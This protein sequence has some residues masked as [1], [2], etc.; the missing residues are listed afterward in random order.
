MVNGG[1]LFID[2]DDP[3]GRSN[4]KKPASQRYNREAR[5]HVMRDI[6]FSRRKEKACVQ[7]PRL[8]PSC[9][10]PIVVDGQPKQHSGSHCR[11]NRCLQDAAK[12]SETKSFG[13]EDDSPTTSSPVEYDA[14]RCAAS[15]APHIGYYR[16]D[17]FVNYP[18]KMTDRRRMLLDTSE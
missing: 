4:A 7:T 16:Q 15:I 3:S 9:Q 8:R 17:P 11:L 10:A 6:G 12:M 1:F 18:I 13:K 2:V 14:D 5:K